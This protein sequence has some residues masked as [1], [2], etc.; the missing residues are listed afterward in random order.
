[1]P[2][3]LQNFYWRI[4][5]YYIDKWKYERNKKM[6]RKK[7]TID[8]GF[9]DVPNCIKCGKKIDIMAYI[10]RRNAYKNNMCLGCTKEATKK[11]ID[12]EKGKKG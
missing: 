11:E 6:T 2:N 4:L 8:L 12:I 1:M 3:K 10:A 5:G 7:I 9:P